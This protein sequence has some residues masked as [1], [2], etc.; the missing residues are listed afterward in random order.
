MCLGQYNSLGEYCGPHTAS[1]V[2]L[3]LLYDHDM[4]NFLMLSA[5][6]SKKRAI[7]ASK[8][9]L[10]GDMVGADARNFPNLDMSFLF[11]DCIIETYTFSF[12]SLSMITVLITEYLCTNYISCR[13][14]L[15]KLIT[16]LREQL[17]FVGCDQVLQR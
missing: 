11:I 3:I 2:C 6:S 17:T 4:Y 9:L 12:L 10:R 7:F 1:S 15:C 8:M 16:P 5:M 14:V 13:V